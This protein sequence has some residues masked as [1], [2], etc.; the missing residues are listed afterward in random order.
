[1]FAIIRREVDRADEITE[2]VIAQ[3]LVGY[4]IIGIAWM[5]VYPAFP[6]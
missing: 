1:M 3:A 6:G 2:D 5:A 4:L